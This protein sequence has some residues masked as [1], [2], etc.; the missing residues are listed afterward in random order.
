MVV[1]DHP[2]LD[3]DREDVAREVPDAPTPD[4]TAVLDDRDRLLLTGA[5]DVEVVAEV[6]VGPNLIRVLVVETKDD[7]DP[8]AVATAEL[9]PAVTY[10]PVLT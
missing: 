10:R 5:P 7:V 6:D 1:L 8:V 2:R 9:D 3:H 4:G